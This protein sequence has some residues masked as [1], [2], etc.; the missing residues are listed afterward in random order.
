[1]IMVVAAPGDGSNIDHFD[2]GKSVPEWRLVPH[3][4]NIGQRATFTVEADGAESLRPA[5]D[6]ARI[7][8]KNPHHKRAH[9]VVKAILPPLLAKR[10]WRLKLAS[11]VA[12]GFPL[13]PY[14]TRNIV[15]RLK[16]G[17]KFTAGQIRKTRDRNICIEVFADDLL[18]GGM[19]YVLEPRARS[20]R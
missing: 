9:M 12:R 2:Q 17:N 6:G 15:L 7:A 18:V 13:A 10:G 19:T 4:N 8:V 3:D 16:P 20:R 14:A 5:F 1:M 11:S